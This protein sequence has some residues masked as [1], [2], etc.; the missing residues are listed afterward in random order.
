ME[1]GVN[2]NKLNETSRLDPRLIISSPL[3]IAGSNGHA[4]IVAILICGG[5]KPEIQNS[6]GITA[7]SKAIGPGM[8]IAN[9]PPLSKADFCLL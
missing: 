9:L 2:P 5:A 6:K 3:H 8:Q 1:H 7:R 4:E